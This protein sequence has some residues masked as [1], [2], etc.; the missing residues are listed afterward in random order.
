MTGLAVAVA[1][2]VPADRAV[3]PTT[4]AR[5]TAEEGSALGRLTSRASARAGWAA[6][7]ATA[8]RRRTD[9]TDAVEC[10]DD[11]TDPAVRPT[12]G[13]DTGERRWTTDAA[14]AA[15]GSLERVGW[16][17]LCAATRRA[18]RDTVEEA[19]TPAGLAT[20]RDC[21]D[22]PIELDADTRAGAAPRAIGCA[23]VD[24]ADVD[25]A[26]VDRAGLS[27]A[28]MGF[29]GPDGPVRARESDA[30]EAG[31]RDTGASDR[32]MGDP[33]DG[34]TG[35]G[36]EGTDARRPAD[37]A[38]GTDSA[39]RSTAGRSFPAVAT[40]IGAGRSTRPDPSR[41]ET[42]SDDA[43]ET[44]GPDAGCRPGDDDSGL[45][46]SNRPT[47]ALD[48]D[49]YTVVRDAEETTG[50]IDGDA[51]LAGVPARAA[52][53]SASG[54]PRSAAM[55]AGDGT[56]VTGDCPDV[57]DAIPPATDRATAKP[58][59]RRATPAGEVSCGRTP[60]V[61]TA[62]LGDAVPGTETGR[63]VDR[64]SAGVPG[65]LAADIGAVTGA[66][67]DGGVDGDVTGRR[68]L[69]VGTGR[70]ARRRRARDRSTVPAGADQAARRAGVGSWVTGPSAPRALE[71]VSL[72]PA[73]RGGRGPLRPRGAGRCWAG[74]GAAERRTPGD[75]GAGRAGGRPGGGAGAGGGAVPS[76]RAC[77][78]RRSNS[79]GSSGA[80]RPDAAWSA[81]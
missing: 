46:S 68:R 26:D 22:D 53:R 2:T 52:T 74:P 39:D 23:D 50:D 45:D 13:A 33:D 73:E 75:E 66:T 10:S 63:L 35:A 44:T 57:G 7:T 12:S 9:V 16:A 24:R 78:P 37:G 34:A 40:R 31:E 70:A 41:R 6:A 51:A 42:A 19:P 79:I 72:S 47:A 65:A 25:R 28:G 29:A 21:A 76:R 58:S 17:S 20:P 3:R 80:T 49:R 4:R 62:V 81:P 14:G 36:V 5:S 67:R 54:R 11:T 56:D 15:T 77:M 30:A 69:A 27:V 1:P 59:A 18:R 71:P 61:G 38:T 8:A 48:A 55:S 32:N 60:K 43:R 64:R